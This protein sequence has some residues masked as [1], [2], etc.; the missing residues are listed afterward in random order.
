MNL[1]KVRTVCFICSANICRSPMAEALLRHMRPNLTVFSRG[2][3]TLGNQPMTNFAAAALVAAG[4]PVPNHR[5]R[6]VCPKDVE[7]ADLILT[8][9]MD[10][11][12]YVVQNFPNALGKT[13]TINPGGDIEDP[14]ASSIAD[15]ERTRNEILYALARTWLPKLEKK[16]R[17]GNYQ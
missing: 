9:T 6:I 14:Y 16:G 13:F 4:I 5:S 10:H 17:S 11:K 3:Y 15:Y 12:E 7:Q 1:K 8:A 2:L